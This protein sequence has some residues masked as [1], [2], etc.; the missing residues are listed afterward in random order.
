[1]TMMTMETGDWLWIFERFRPAI[2]DDSGILP[3]S[4]LAL[5]RA[6]SAS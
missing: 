4:A 6:G 3:E 1:M 2:F 5:T